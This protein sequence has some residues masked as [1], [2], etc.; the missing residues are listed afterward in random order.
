MAHVPGLKHDIFISYAHADSSEWVNAF[1]AGL[2]ARLQQRWGIR[3]DFWQDT[4]KIRIG[5]QW[6]QEIEEG[7]NN[8][9]AFVALVSPS[10]RDSAWCSRERRLFL[11]GFPSPQDSLVEDISRLM[12]VIKTPY[13]DGGHRELLAALQD[14]PFFK[15]APPL[16]I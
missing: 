10:Y 7:I 15:T 12:K 1:R 9:A 13:P 4:Q 2:A 14:Y 11:S 3:A 6:A 16:T 5:H 8:C